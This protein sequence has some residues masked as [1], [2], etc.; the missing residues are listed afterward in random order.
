MEPWLKA[1]EA[2]GFPAWAVVILIAWLSI[3]KEIRLLA[4]KFA[5]WKDELYEWRIGLEKRVVRTETKLGI[6]NENE[7]H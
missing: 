2:L 1:A 3:K 7:S 4:I 6:D 5:E